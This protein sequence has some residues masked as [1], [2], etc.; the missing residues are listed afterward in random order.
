MK[1][2]WQVLCTAAVLA[3]GMSAAGVTSGMGVIAAR[4]DEDPAYKK[5]MDQAG[6]ALV[7]VKFVLKIDGGEQMGG[8]SEQEMESTGFLIDGK[9]LVI[10]SNFQVGGYFSMMARNGGP[11]AT[12][13]DVK[14]L[15]GDDTEG[16]KATVISRDTELDLAWV[17]LDEE[18]TSD[19]KHIDMS[20]GVEAPTGTRV[21]L[22]GRMAKFFDRA[23]S[24]SEGKISGV[25]EKPRKLL[26]PTKPLVSSRDD[27]GMPVF[28]SD[29]GVVGMVVI[30]LPDPESMEGDAT[31]SLGGGPM[32][33]PAAEIVKATKRALEAAAKPTEAPKADAPAAEPSK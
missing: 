19:L 24:I 10:C 25:T 12:P 33:L 14:I 2:A 13:T 4:P 26:S 7:T 31:G 1:K 32:I 17:K 22:L 6:P 21:L 20:S 27:L 9:G 11:T 8:P 30:Q 18:S 15:I 16:K 23:M 3:V 29:G 5:I 28:N